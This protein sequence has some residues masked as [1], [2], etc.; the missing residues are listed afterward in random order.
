MTHFTLETLWKEVHFTPNTQQERAIRHVDGPLY[1]PAGPGSGKTRVLL[2]RT[3]NLIVFHGVSPDEIFLSTFTE[4]AALQLQEGLRFLLG[5]AANYS[6][7]QYDISNMFVGTVHSLCRKLIADRRFYRGRARPHPPTILDELS[8]Y[9]HLSRRKQWRKLTYDAGFGDDASF[10]INK[11]FTGH[12]SQSKF[13][14]VKETISLFNRFSEE[15]L[16]PDDVLDDTEDETLELLLEMYKVYRDDLET[17]HPVPLTDLSLLQQRALNVLNNFEDA[18]SVFR[19]VIIDEYQDT[20]TVQEKIFFKLAAGHKNLCVVGD[21][22]QALYRFRGATVENFV[23][24]PKRCQTH[25]GQ[26]PTKIP[27]SI[28]YRS[29]KEIVD[30]YTR[31]MDETDWRKEENPSEFYRVVD[32]DIR[33]FS[34]DANAAVVATSPTKP[35]EAFEEIAELVET[36][37]AEGKVSDPNQ[38]AFLFPSLKSEQVSRM[39]AALEAKGLEVYAPRAGRFLETEEAVAMFG[40]IFRIIGKPMRGNFPGRDFND[41]HDWVDQAYTTAGELIDSEP[42]LKTFVQDKHAE[43]AQSKSDYVALMKVVKQNKWDINAPYNPGVMKR[44]LLNAGISSQAKKGVSN[45]YF[46]RIVRK[47][48]DEGQP[49]NLRY[50]LNRATSLDWTMLDLFYRLC[51]F[52]HFKAMFDA[53][54]RLDDARDEGPIANLG[55]ISQYIARFVDEHVSIATGQVLADDL[56]SAIFAAYLYVLYRMGESEYEDADDPFPKGRIPFLTIHQSKGLEFPVVVLPNPRKKDNGPQFIETIVRPMLNRE[57]EPLERSSE[58]DIMRMF[59]VAL[60]RAENLLVLA[61]LSSRGNYVNKP[62]KKLFADGITR[63]KDFDVSTM[64]AAQADDRELPKNYSY[65]GDFLLYRKCPRQYLVFRKYGFVPSRS[66]VMFFGS[67]VHR[68]LE[69]LHQHLIAEKEVH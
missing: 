41:F 22:D 7:K 34:T 26:T 33:A 52:N 11:F 21:D 2:W 67:L 53:A 10:E 25:L 18:G 62:F 65:T 46:D 45:Y 55:L 13:R 68:T 3:V 42:P 19:F 20:N 12:G 29:R 9:Y 32:K 17:G 44:P 43:I 39:K 61:H 24:F 30:F 16:N 66:Q 28:N 14:A 69:D 58:F 36:L 37:L 64:P 63:I 56:F 40:V 31:F 54:A 50:I 15:V 38:I 60:S 8:Q 4:K 23:E 51:G 27:L 57:G 5:I 6:N 59:Y 35:V 47:R 49:F 1:L 48:I